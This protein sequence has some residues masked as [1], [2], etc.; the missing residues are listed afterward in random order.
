[1]TIMQMQLH[2]NPYS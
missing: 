1:M 2:S